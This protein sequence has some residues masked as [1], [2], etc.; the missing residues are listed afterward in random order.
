M[1][2]RLA[3]APRV[4]AA[5][6]LVAAASA[7]CAPGLRKV[8]T[9]D[10]AFV[11]GF[12]AVPEKVGDANCV[13][14]IQDEKVGIAGRAGCM[15]TSPEGLF[16]AED[17]P[18]MRYNI[19]G[20]YVDRTFNALGDMAKP[21]AVKPGELRLY[22]IYRYQVVYKPLLVGQ[23]KFSLTPGGP[24]HAEV[25]RKLLQQESISAKWKKRIQARLRELGG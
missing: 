11:Y 7:G 12:F 2:R 24:S 15:S 20:F 14:I 1:V 10:G 3:A 8:S 23:G 19:H 18:P 22:G 5:L 4:L 9:P 17:L 25:L 16:F 13:G 21:F 6:A